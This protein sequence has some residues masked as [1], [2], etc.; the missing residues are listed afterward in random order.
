MGVID[1][2]GEENMILEKNILHF[3]VQ[4]RDIQIVKEI[5]EEIDDLFDEDNL[6]GIKHY[7]DYVVVSLNLL[8]NLNV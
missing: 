6:K 8:E 5:F 2:F 7:G 3:P 1:D 4:N